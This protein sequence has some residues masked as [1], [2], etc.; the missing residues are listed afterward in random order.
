[1][2]INRVWS[3]PNKNTFSIRPI[4]EL[5]ESYINIVKESNPNAVIIDL[6]PILTN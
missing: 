3:M 6:L 4:K 2:K 1:M 5:I